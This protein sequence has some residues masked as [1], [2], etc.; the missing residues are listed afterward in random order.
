MAQLEIA[1]G[2][3]YALLAEEARLIA[4]RDGDDQISFPAELTDQLDAPRPR[5]GPTVG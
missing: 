5:G 3:Y 1:R 2:Q 4:E